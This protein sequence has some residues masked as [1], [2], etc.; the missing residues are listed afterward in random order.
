LKTAENTPETEKVEEKQPDETNAKQPQYVTT[1]ELYQTCC[2][3]SVVVCFTTIALYHQFGATRLA[4]AD[5]NGYMGKVAQ[6]NAL[7]VMSE[8]QV[9]EAV[10]VAGNIINSQRHNVVVLSGD[11]VLG[12]AKPVRRIAMPDIKFEPPAKAA[13]P[14]ANVQPLMPQQQ[15][16]PA[17]K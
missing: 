7:G 16:A 13:A 14:A 17:A 1:K 10:D 3:V 5:L 11:V 4:V 15:P 6:A 9:D 12:D 8:K 2:L